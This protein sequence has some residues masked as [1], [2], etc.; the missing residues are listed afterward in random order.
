MSKRLGK[1]QEK[2]LREYPERADEQDVKTLLAEI[3]YWRKVSAKLV[4]IWK[5]ATKLIKIEYDI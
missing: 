2:W 5:G 4:E 3:D 1:K